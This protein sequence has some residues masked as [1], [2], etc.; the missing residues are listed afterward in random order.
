MGFYAISSCD[1]VFIFQETMVSVA[2]YLVDDF[3]LALDNL[4]PQF[5]TVENCQS[6]LI[7]DFRQL[8]KTYLCL[9]FLGSWLAE[10]TFTP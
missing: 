5:V 1:S 7:R 3:G 8:I 4:L 6:K 2:D 10:L 9:P